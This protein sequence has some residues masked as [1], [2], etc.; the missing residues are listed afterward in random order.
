MKPGTQIAYIPMH[1]DGDVS[2]PDVEFGFITSV[3]GNIAFC[4]YWFKGKPGDLRTR[5]VSESTM[6]E[7]II[8]HESVPQ[9]RVE[10]ALAAIEAPK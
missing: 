1:A 10:Q 5:L 4:R 9:A 7:D 8:S 3:R 2:H 6:L